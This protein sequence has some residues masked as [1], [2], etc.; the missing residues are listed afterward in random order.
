VAAVPPP[1]VTQAVGLLAAGLAH[2]LNNMLGGIVATAELLAARARPDSADGRDL[3]AI[4]AQAAK[5]SALIRQ[6]L[7]FSRQDVLQPRVLTLGALLE[8]LLPT[9]GAMAGPR[10]KLEHAVT[11][12]PKPMLRA[13]PSALERV[14]VNLVLNARD[15]LGQGGG[16]IR[17]STARIGPNGLPRAG[18]AFMP[19]ISYVA[20]AVEDDGP[21]IAP[22][23]A[24]RI[25]EPY[26]TT[27]PQGQ[28][29]GL[30]TAYGI[31]KQSGGFLLYDPA[32]IGGAR[33]TIYLPE[34]EAKDLRLPP[35]RRESGVRTIL[36]AEDEALLRASAAR[37][38]ERLGYQVLQAGDGASA[39]ALLADS[40]DVSLL[41][42]DIRMPVMDG[43]DLTRAAR[44]LR[45]DLPVIL[46]S[47]YADE[48]AR[49]AV[50]DLDV[51]FMAK[52]FGL[53]DL[54]ASID[55]LL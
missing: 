35:L 33:F 20:V 42:S 3:A 46:V 48:A 8:S 54:A 24:A 45:P 34:C 16:R 36:F 30:A 53:K 19:A 26:F 49:A 9:L 51:A 14:I 1:V 22:A 40:P 47:G 2:D 28:G 55:S 18:A 21:G 44:K 6:I 5:A 43:I 41:L 52:P 38:L 27:K 12:G 29:L 25:F 31:V 17:I 4:V 7:A 39:L 11:E 50:P 10:I 37:G 32:P 15:A 13:D 23:I